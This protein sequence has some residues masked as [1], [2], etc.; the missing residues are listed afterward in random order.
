MGNVWEWIIVQ[1]GPVPSIAVRSVTQ[2]G[3]YVDEPVDD[4]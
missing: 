1:F 4:A 3:A 2:P